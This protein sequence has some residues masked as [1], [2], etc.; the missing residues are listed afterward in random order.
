MCGVPQGSILGPILFTMYT[1]S[2]GNLIKHFDVSYHL[3]ADDTQ[4]Y[5]SCDNGNI[6][7]AY[8][9]MQSC[10][11]QVQLWMQQHNLKMNEDK[12]EFIILKS[13]W[14]SIATTK[15]L[16]INNHEI[17]PSQV[18]RNIGA[19][20]D[21]TLSMKSHVTEICKKSYLQIRTINKVK[22]FLDRA[23]LEQIIH[24]FITSRLDFCNSLLDG[25]NGIEINRLQKIQNAAARLITNC[26]WREHITP[27]LHALHWLPIEQRIKFK[28]LCLVYKSVNNLAPYYLSD[29]ILPYN[30]TR[31]LRSETQ[32]LLRVPFTTSTM[33]KHRCFDISGPS[34]WNSL[35]HQILQLLQ[36]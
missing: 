14:T 4:L 21:S 20:F 19:H 13:K 8:E 5:V 6:N 31:A 33:E 28:L 23:S 3:Y 17:N 12:T 26:P 35:P 18:V 11:K 25:V 22:H 9:R 34:L 1:S 2:L 7:Q 15:P 24:A 10:I 32:N 16:I 36:S 29:Y 27:A 30:P